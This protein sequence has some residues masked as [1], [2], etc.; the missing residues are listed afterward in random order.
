MHGLK[1]SVALSVA[2]FVSIIALGCGGSGSSS[3]PAKPGTASASPTPSPSPAASP[4]PA[5]SPTPSPSPTPNSTTISGIQN[6][7]GWESC[8]GTCTNTATAVFALTQGVASPSMSGSSAEFQLLSGT[9]PFGAAL[10]FKFLGS[11]PSA[12][13]FVY[14]LWFFIDD[15]SASQALEFNVAQAAHGNR[16]N[17]STQCL[18]AGKNIW[19]VWDPSTGS[20]SASSA[21]CPPPAANTWNHL[22]WEVERDFSDNVIFTA[23]TVNGTRQLVNLTMGHTADS[24]NGLDVAFQ[25]DADLSATPYAV[26]LDKVSL[27]FW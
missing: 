23:V 19:R 8:T 11:F 2:G 15:P 4:T 26:Y 6:L 22:I 14:D 13:H 27:T 1:L 25:P 24:T 7:A 16:Y 5:G 17:F 3:D 10:W 12:T 21:H 9:Q 18:F 20:W